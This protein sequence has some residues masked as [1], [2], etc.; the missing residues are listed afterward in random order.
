[1]P[2]NICI[3]NFFQGKGVM[4]NDEWKIVDTEHK[5]VDRKQMESVKEKG[6]E[7]KRDS[8]KEKRKRK[9]TDWIIDN[10]SL[11]T[12]SPWLTTYES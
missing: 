10:Q 11:I 4:R 8:D 6:R 3:G 5:N 1:M 9:E 2:L 7:K 12:S